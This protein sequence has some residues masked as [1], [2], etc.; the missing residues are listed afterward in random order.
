MR[1][2]NH[3]S[4]NSSIAPGGTLTVEPIT[5][6][7]NNLSR[8]VRRRLSSNVAGATAS[9]NGGLGHSMGYFSSLVDFLNLNTRTLMQRPFRE[10]ETDYL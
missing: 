4:L 7:G 10:I 3:A 9:G 1:C 6:S 2:N 5:A 8:N